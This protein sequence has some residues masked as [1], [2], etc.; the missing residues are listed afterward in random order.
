MPQF[1]HIETFTDLPVNLISGIGDML[2]TEQGGNRMLYAATRAGGGVVAFDIDAGMAVADQL[3]FNVA[4]QLP[5][6]PTLDLCSANGN[7][8]LVVSGSNQTTMLSYRVEATGTI[9]GIFKP[10]GGPVGV[11]SAQSVLDLDG[12]SY[13][14]AAR[15]NDGAVCAWRMAANGTLTLVQDLALAPDLQGV[16]IADMIEIQAGGSRFLAVAAPGDDRIS[17]LRVAADGR[18]SL[19]DSIGAANGLGIADPGEMRALSAHGASYLLVASASSSSLT[20]LAVSAEGALRVTDHLIDTLDTRFQSVSA[21]EGFAWNGR[22]FVLAGGGDG[23]LGLFE[24]LPDGR[25]VL[26]AQMLDTPGMSLEAITAL[27]V[28]GT[29]TGIEVFVGGEGTGIT[30]LSLD[31]AALAA[32]QLG[33]GA[34]DTMA[35]GGLD[36]L[37]WAGAGNDLLQGGA[38]ADTLADGAGSDQLYGGA[39]ADLFVLA[40]DGATDTIRDFQPGL[41]RLDL[42]S[43]SALLDLSELI[44]TPTAW[45]AQ[46]LFQGESLNVYSANGLPLGRSQ[47]LA[48]GPFTLW[49]AS[50]ATLDAG[51]VQGTE[52]AEFLSGRRTGTVTFQAMG[53]NDTMA[54]SA[55]V[56]AFD[57]AAGRDCVTYSDATAGLRADLQV[58]ATN[59]GFAAGDSYSGIED[60]QGSNHA[61]L[62]YGNA[63]ANA[64]WGGVGNDILSGRDG[65]DSLYGGD[66]NDVLF[67]G[68]GADRL[69][70]GAGVRDR[71][72]YNDAT[73]GLRADLQ[74][75]ITNSGEAAG[76]AFVGIEDLQGGNYADALLGDVGA[77]MLWG[78]EGNDSLCGRAGN[79]SLYGG[80]GNDI[81]LG[82]AGIDLINGGSGT[83]DRLQYTDSSAGLRVDL[84]TP[85]TNTG[86]AAGDSYSD[87]EDLYGSGYS[88]TLLGNGGANI[89]W[90]A[91]GQDILYGRGSNDT[92]Y[93]GE[94]NDSLTGGVG[95]DLHDGGAGTRDRAQ[96]SDANAGLRADLITSGTNT[97]YA[98]G[99]S[100]VGIEDLLG[101]N[102]ADTLLGNDGANM[103]WG[104][105]GN[106]ILYGR[107]GND[108]LSGGEGNDSLAGGAGADR[109]DGGAGARDR[110]QYGDAIAGLRADLQSPGANTGFAAGDSYVG[111]EDLLGSDFSDTLL[112]DGAANMIWGAAGHD[113]IYGRAGNDTISG[114][115]GNDLLGGNEGN[116]TLTGNAGADSFVFDRALG[117]GNVDRLADFTAADDTIRLDDAIFTTLA[118]GGL[119]GTAFVAGAAA[120]TAA[121]RIVYNQATGQIF[122]DSDGSG[123]A[124]AILFATAT[125]GTAIGAADFLVT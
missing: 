60:L 75:P 114:G 17:L 47:I 5:V 115:E 97:G 68:V 103:V 91:A 27:A 96:Y 2:I 89:V 76:D 16:S 9:G 84:E 10:A 88:D 33:S 4:S 29:A 77:N 119:A 87:V 54:G 100:Y 62:L 105:A 72:Q 120:T 26:A 15:A 80:S 6:A 61:D 85:N 118:T 104:A 41:D 102:F 13:F 79:D 53:G 18:L 42:S 122:Y 121:H 7:R 71:A 49:H 25:L 51:Q 38:G 55:A 23:G 66:G 32:P 106:D 123:S 67:G 94:G 57:G 64:L 43:W 28:Q 40:A 58:A 8:Y 125:P 86:I 48:A 3:T 112:G 36:D 39:G 34:A 101:S 81:L 22:S 45:G 12:T 110:A 93:G 113:T 14:Y 56:E 1:S 73:A 30:R 37:I 117:A 44:V 92:L 107:V 82:G 50:L 24:V 78:A 98:A 124:L 116:D 21:L 46:I 74:S 31:L 35:G 90:G 70:G 11:I 19:A 109:L 83:R 99:D 59:T 52:G 20:V 95:A 111:I 63:G 108:T 65:L 69:D